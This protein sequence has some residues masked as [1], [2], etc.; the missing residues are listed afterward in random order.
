MV[1]GGRGSV[2]EVHQGIARTAGKKQAASTLT[3]CNETL[4]HVRQS[5]YTEEKRWRETN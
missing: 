1:G 2:L 3:S 5:A 4:I